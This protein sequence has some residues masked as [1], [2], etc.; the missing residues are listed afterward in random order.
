M[1]IISKKILREFWAKNPDA[2]KPIMYWYRITKKANWNSIADVKKDFRH[3]DAA[4]VCTIFNIGG[5]NFRVITKIFYQS[6]KV[7]IRFVMTH[8][9]YNRKGYK[10][11]CEC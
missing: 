8:A 7:L 5:N 10:N 1:R 3:A 4:G 11:D 6:K 2:E 9:E